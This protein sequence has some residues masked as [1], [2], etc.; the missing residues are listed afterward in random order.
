[1]A[2]AFKRRKIKT[3]SG[4]VELRVVR[5][6]F[7]EILDDITTGRVNGLLA[8]DLD[9]ACRD[10]RD[11]EDLLDACAQTGAS[12]RGSGSLMLTNGGNDGEQFMAR[13]MVAIANKSS[14]DTA[15]RV[16]EG[17]ERHWGESYRAACA[18]SG[19]SRPRTRRH[20][21]GRC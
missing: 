21:T 20:I 2:S 17:R 15:R 9:R 4:R 3:P 16:A 1:M 18:R 11:L 5:P 10:P 14:S 19:T 8:E 12:A 7:R 13:V 6:G